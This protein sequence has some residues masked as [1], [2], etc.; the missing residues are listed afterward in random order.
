MSDTNNRDLNY[1]SSLDRA[2]RRRNRN[3]YQRYAL[4]GGGVRA[5]PRESPIRYINGQSSSKRLN[6]AACAGRMTMLRRFFFWPLALPIMLFPILAQA[7]AILENSTPS[8]GATV[9]AGP[10]PQL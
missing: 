3:R 9:K 4:I 7:H 10:Y 8:A 5:T 6:G 2:R 1:R